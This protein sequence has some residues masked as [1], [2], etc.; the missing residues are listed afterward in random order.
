MVR[1]FYHSVRTLAAQEKL[2]T[3][4]LSLALLA[5]FIAFQYEPGFYNGPM[6]LVYGFCES[7]LLFYRRRDRVILRTNT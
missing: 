2:I 4:A 6:W 3:R 5:I 7:I 1:L